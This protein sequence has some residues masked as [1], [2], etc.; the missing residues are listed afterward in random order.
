LAKN[1]KS[2]KPRFFDAIRAALRKLF[3]GFPGYFPETDPA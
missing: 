3:V 1:A 2:D